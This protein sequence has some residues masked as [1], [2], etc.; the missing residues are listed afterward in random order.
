MT[1]SSHLVLG[2]E[3]SSRLIGV[4]LLRDGAVLSSVERMSLR[5][6]ADDLRALVDTILQDAGA[7][8]AD[9]TGVAVS[10]G[11]G[12][13]TGLRIGVSFVK[14]LVTGHAVLLA[15]VPTLDVIAHN[16]WG[17]RGTLVVLLDAKQDKVYAAAYRATPQGLRRLTHDRLG[18][19]AELHSL[20]KRGTLFTGDGVAVYRTALR[21][22]LRRAITM[23]PAECWWPRAV[24]VARLGAEALA[25]GQRADP[26]TLR[27]MYLYS[28]TCSITP[29]RRRTP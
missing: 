15:G 21:R 16:C 9:L 17:A 20:L 27:P 14:G 13:F 26:K 11:P 8:L 4:A 23:A 2:V 6:H 5:P 24:T 25:R 7:R 12:S 1:A 28:G 29:A 3:T 18:T 19:P 22:Q 10:L